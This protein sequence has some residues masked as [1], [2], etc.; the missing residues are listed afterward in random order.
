MIKK[1]F[2]FLFKKK[3]ETPLISEFAL[4]RR[5][6]TA[7]IK[8]IDDEFNKIIEHYK[9]GKIIAEYPYSE[10]QI[11][12]IK[13]VDEIPVLDVDTFQEEDSEFFWDEPIEFGVVKEER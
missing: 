10:A 4:I 13:K 3:E 11:N 6:D 1:I 5:T 7:K 9:N 2:P 8:G 12:A